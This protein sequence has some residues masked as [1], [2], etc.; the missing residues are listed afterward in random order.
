VAVSPGLI[1]DTGLNRS[2]AV[3]TFTMDMP[4]AKT[5]E[6]GTRATQLLD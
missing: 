4:D 6:E 5:V 2:K 1:P 3:P